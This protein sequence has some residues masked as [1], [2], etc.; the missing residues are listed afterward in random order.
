MK[1]IFSVAGKIAVVT[2]GSSGIGAMIARG[3]VEHGVK[4]YITARKPE[5]LE[6]AATELSQRGQCIALQS[7][8]S[9]VDG[10]A[11]LVAALRAQED[12]IDILINNA[13]ANWGAPLAEYPESGWDKVMNVNLKSVFFLTQRLL[14]ALRAAATADDPARVVNIASING[15]TYPGMSTYAYSSSKAG[16]IQLTR[17]LAAELAP[18][19][20]NINAIAPGFFPSKMTRE[21]LLKAQAMA[22]EIPMRRLGCAEDVAGTAIF[23]CSRAGNYV[24]GHTLVMDGGL[25]AQAG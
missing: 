22:Q 21:L 18:E 14:P 9:T 23:L 6:A 7:D 25:V 11:A 16:L 13:G 5:Q 2:G 19:H 1:N 15:L 3:F 4:T 8:L 17:H 12:K 24:C 20:I 10:V